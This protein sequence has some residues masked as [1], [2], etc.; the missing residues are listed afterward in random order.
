MVLMRGASVVL[1]AVLLSTFPCRVISAQS[2]GATPFNAQTRIKDAEIAK[3]GTVQIT[4]NNGRSIQVPAERGQAE[5]QRLQVAASGYSV[6]WLVDDVSVGSYSVPSTLTVYTVGK[7]LRHFGDRLMLLDWDFIDD[8]KHIRFS[9]S[10]AHGPG[11]DW[12]T[13]EVHDLETGRLL[14]RWLEQ[15]S[16]AVAPVSL[17][18]ITGLVTGERGVA[19]PDTVVTV[20]A[21]HAAEPFALT[22]SIEGGH[23][24]LQGIWPGEHELRFEH[25]GFK[26]RSIKI[27]VSD[28][29][30]SIDTGAV[31]L[32]RQ[33]A[34]G[35]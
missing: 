34:P 22:I 26:T 5:R 25:P 11:T 16:T 17:T 4:F 30:E 33:P 32:E 14:N 1:L 9:S 21:E 8:D 24:A 23:F 35:K 19:L 29:A 28:S 12:L 20:R 13:M 7:P 3:D 15:S 2:K 6:G 31:T 27:A 18:S 10:Q